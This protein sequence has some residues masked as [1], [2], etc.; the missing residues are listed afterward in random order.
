MK[1]ISYST[2][3]VFFAFLMIGRHSLADRTTMVDPGSLKE[4]H[5]EIP[6]AETPVAAIFAELTSDTTVK[7]EGALLWLLRFN[8]A[9]ELS[10]FSFP[11]HSI[12]F[13]VERVSVRETGGIVW[14][15]VECEYVE[16]DAGMISGGTEYHA[17]WQV[18]YLFDDLGHLR[19]WIADYD[20]LT[21][22]DLN[23]DQCLDILAYI[24]SPKCVVV[25]EYERGRCREILWVDEEP[26]HGPE[27]S[28][29]PVPTGGYTVKYAPPVEIVAP[30]DGRAKQISIV[31][32]GTYAWS[33]W[34]E[35]YVGSEE[36]K[37]Q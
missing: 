15:L 37:R 8:N 1:P 22:D 13:G 3:L 4:Q 14:R 24:R 5:T 29:T 7:K 6:V 21:V 30:P 32:H 20:C 17:Y 36:L 18:A 19:D 12:N 26:T 16:R 27:I 31:G 9:M 2:I 23:G 28:R 33:K 35:R 11:K 25:S 34:K 10:Y